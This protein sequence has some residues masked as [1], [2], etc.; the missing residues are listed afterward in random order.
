MTNDSR[1]SIGHV[2]YTKR[3]KQVVKMEVIGIKSQPE[4]IELVKFI[5]SLF[6]DKELI[7]WNG[8]FDKTFVYN[9]I[10]N[11]EANDVDSDFSGFALQIEQGKSEFST[12]ITLLRTD[13]KF[14]EERE[15][16]LALKL[17]DK[18]KCR[19]I[20]NGPEKLADHPFFSLIIENGKIYEA[21][22]EGTDWG[23]GTELGIE[24]KIIR[25]ME[26]EMEKFDFDK[27]GNIVQ[28][29]C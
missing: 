16:F 5:H 3:K 27:S 1:L 26:M 18:L 19:T 4:R 22:D 21:D 23:D 13:E 6:P 9:G 7:N 25:E 14:S 15:L 11:T 10:E 20:I 28:V 29:S 24:V 8:N 12:I 2:C 17:S